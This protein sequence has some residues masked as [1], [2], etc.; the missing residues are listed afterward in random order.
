MTVW[1]T[2]PLRTLTAETHPAGAVIAVWFGAEVTATSRFPAVDGAGRVLVLLVV[3][4]A[5][6]WTSDHA[7][8][9]LT[10]GRA[11]TGARAMSGAPSP[12][13]A[14]RGRRAPSPPGPLKRK[15]A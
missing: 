3:C 10:A 9:H 12:G 14:S 2:V 6:C 1:L 11:R 13:R 15:V 4:A 8:G 7:T 5:D